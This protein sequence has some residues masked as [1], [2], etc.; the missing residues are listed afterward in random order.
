MNQFLMDPTCRSCGGYPCDC[1]RAIGVPIQTA[2]GLMI[3][4][5]LSGL[6]PYEPPRELTQEELAANRRLQRQRQEQYDDVQRKE[7]EKGV[8]EDQRTATKFLLEAIRS[9]D[10]GMARKAL[11]F[12]ANIEKAWSNDD[13]P[14]HLAIKRGNIE[15]TR[16]LLENEPNVNAKGAR[17][18]TRASEFTPLIDAVRTNNKEIVQLLLA[19]QAST[20]ATDNVGRTPA[21]QPCNPDILAML[22]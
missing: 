5:G 15:I 21:Q 12:G 19:H 13:A 20:S 22:K 7:F 4:D 17:S 9:N 3:R 11:G 16:L 18:S 10:V 6:R 1:G 2:N 14:L 8:C